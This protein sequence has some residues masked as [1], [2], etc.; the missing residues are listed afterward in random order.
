MSTRDDI[1][2]AALTVVGEQ[3]VAGLTNRRIAA[4]A[5]VSLGSLTYHFA[6]QTELLREAMLR[7]AEQEAAQLT[8]L[9]EAHRAEGLGLEEVARLVERVIEQLPFGTNEIAALELYLHAGRDGGLRESA[10][11]CFAGYDEL[12]T[13]VLTA[14]GVPEP[15]RTATQVVALIVGMQLRRLATGEPQPAAEAL[16][17]LVS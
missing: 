3:G 17:R 10:R 4:A 13:T 5:G 6:S 16:T 9:A 15:E 7:F 1:L 2:R 14:L 11:R 8:A 12:A